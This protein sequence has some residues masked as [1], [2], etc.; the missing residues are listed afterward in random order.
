MDK[1]VENK[2]VAA[3]GDVLDF[4]HMG[5]YLL[6]RAGEKMY[7]LVSL[8]G[9]VGNLKTKPWIWNGINKKIPLPVETYSPEYG[10]IPDNLGK[11]KGIICTKQVPVTTYK[12]EDVTIKF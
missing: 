9:L 10:G 3:M 4:H 1:K 12:E 8:S 11:L 7:A 6:V 2:V 5:L